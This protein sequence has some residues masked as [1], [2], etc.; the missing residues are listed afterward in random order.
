MS[1][2]T[3]VFVRAFYR[4]GSLVHTIGEEV[5]PG[6]FSPDVIDKALD[7]DF[8]IESPQRRSLHRIFHRF[9]GATP[10][11]PLSNEERNDLC[12]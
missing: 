6:L 9:T 1:R 11:Q 5:P 4:D 8:L 7:E 2:P 10:E 3:L 12:L